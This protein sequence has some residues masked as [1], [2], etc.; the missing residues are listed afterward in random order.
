MSKEALNNV[1]IMTDV[2]ASKGYVDVGYLN[3]CLVA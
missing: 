3:S 2:A 1:Y